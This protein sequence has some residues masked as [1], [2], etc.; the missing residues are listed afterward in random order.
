MLHDFVMEVQVQVHYR[1]QEALVN[2]GVNKADIFQTNDLSE[3]KD[4]ANV[5]NTMFA[6]GRTVRL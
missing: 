6:L 4:L 3:K 1:F 5:T 2:Y